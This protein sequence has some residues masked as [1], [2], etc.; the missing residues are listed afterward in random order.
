MELLI[1]LTQKRLR[2]VVIKTW[3]G[4]CDQDM[5]GK[6]FD[7]EFVI[8]LANPAPANLAVRPSNPNW[9]VGRAISG[10]SGTSATSNVA[11]VFSEG[12]PWGKDD[13]I[14]VDGMPNYLTKGERS[15]YSFPV[16]WRSEQGAGSIGVI[17]VSS[18]EPNS[19]SEQLKQAINLLANVVGFIFTLYAI[20][21]R[22][23]LEKE[24]ANAKKYSKHPG[25]GI[26]IV[27]D[28]AD[29][30]RFGAGVSGLRRQIAGYFEDRML[31]EHRH[32]WVNGKLTYAKDWNS[33]SS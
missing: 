23:V 9:R 6:E 14:L 7:A 5:D 27:S 16:E 19:I 12:R 26:H 22:E 10:F 32:S 8:G 3:M 15:V 24:G 31:R 30:Q 2:R 21:S 33:V 18:R 29:A 4:C 11:K 20:G 13:V 25:S 17:T 1:Y 28:A